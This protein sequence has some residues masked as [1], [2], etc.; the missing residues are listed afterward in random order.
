MS[1]INKDITVMY[2]ESSLSSMPIKHKSLNTKH[3]LVR[4]DLCSC[5]FVWNCQYFN[6]N[7][8]Y[9]TK[10]DL[11]GSFK[12]TMF[13]AKKTSHEHIVYGNKKH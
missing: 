10:S 2:D 4:K 9:F 7:N 5:F 12:K 8:P 3:Y 6:W 11:K 13:P 1:R